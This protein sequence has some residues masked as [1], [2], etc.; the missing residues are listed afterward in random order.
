VRNFCRNL[1][2]HVVLNLARLARLAIYIF[3]RH[4][5]WIGAGWGKILRS[6]QPVSVGNECDGAGRSSCWESQWSDRS[7]GRGDEGGQVGRQLIRELSLHGGTTALIKL[8]MPAEWPHRERDF[9]E[10][11]REE[12]TE[13]AEIENWTE[14]GHWVFIKR[15]HAGSMQHIRRGDVGSRPCVSQGLGCGWVDGKARWQQGE[16]GMGKALRK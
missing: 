15:P 11:S 13:R 10:N 1:E 7:R 14:A 9:R 5:G 3:A 12:W 4:C 6:R 8:E 2:Q 16:T